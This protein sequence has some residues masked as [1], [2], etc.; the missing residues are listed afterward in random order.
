MKTLRRVSKCVG[1]S[2]EGVSGMFLLLSCCSE[3]LPSI[4]SLTMNSHFGI[5]NILR[6]K[7]WNVEILCD[8]YHWNLFGPIGSCNKPIGSGKNQGVT[9]SSLKPKKENKAAKCCCCSRSMYFFNCCIK[10]KDK[11]SVLKTSLQSPVSHGAASSSSVGL[12]QWHLGGVTQQNPIGQHCWRVALS[13]FL[14]WRWL[15]KHFQ[16]VL[17]KLTHLCVQVAKNKDQQIRSH[18]ISTN[19]YLK[20]EWQLYPPH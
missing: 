3:T 2:G 11:N 6:Q 8:S 20:R 10:I 1:M 7:K 14:Q 18:F 4:G 16:N 19:L 9:A 13:L 15:N 5:L 17:L 12:W